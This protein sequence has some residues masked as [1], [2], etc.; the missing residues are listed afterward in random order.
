[1]TNTTYKAYNEKIDE[2]IEGRRILDICNNKLE[3]FSFM[4]N[5]DFDSSGLRKFL[6]I[7]NLAVNILN[8][9]KGKIF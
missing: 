9:E 5:T 2:I 6:L 8:S 1:M 3:K 7:S 4:D